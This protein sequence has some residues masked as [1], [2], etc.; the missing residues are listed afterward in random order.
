MIQSASSKS[1][2]AL[3]FA[4]FE[5][6]GLTYVR[7]SC[8]KIVKWWSAEWI[9][10]KWWKN[11]QDLVEWF[12]IFDRNTVKIL[13]NDQNPRRL[14]FLI[15]RGTPQSSKENRKKSEDRWGKEQIDKFERLSIRERHLLRF[16]IQRQSKR[17]ESRSIALSFHIFHF[18]SK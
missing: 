10:K 18:S 9:I 5:V 12:P 14:P 4:W 7:T 11:E 13:I 1:Q 16:N 8:V 15:Q 17:Q 2:P 6:L 3:I